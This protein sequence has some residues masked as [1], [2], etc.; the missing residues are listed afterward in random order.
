MLTRSVHCKRVAVTEC[1]AGDTCA[2]S[3]RS[4]KKKRPLVRSDIRRGMVLVDPTDAPK[5]VNIP[6]KTSKNPLKNLC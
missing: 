1:R 5:P 3:L 6:L 4:L 2:V